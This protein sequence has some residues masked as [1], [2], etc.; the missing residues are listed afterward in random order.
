MK[1]LRTHSESAFTIVE[2][3]IVI[4]VIGILA[5]I[6]IVAYNGIQSKA[7]VA[8]LQSDLENSNKQLVAYLTT[9]STGYPVAIDCSASPAANTLCLKSSGATTYQYSVN[10]STLSAPAYCITATNGAKSYFYSPTTGTPTIGACP[11]HGVGGTAPI[12]NLSLNPSLE[13][14]Q[15][16]WLAGSNSVTINRISDSMIGSYSLAET[17]VT[18]GVAYIYNALP[19]QQPITAGTTYAVS[20]SVKV[21]TGTTK[22]FYLGMIWR[23]SAG[24][25]ISPVYSSA[26]TPSGVGVVTRLFMTATAP[27]SATSLQIQGRTD[28]AVVGDQYNW[29]G[30][31]MTTG[32]T[33]YAYADGNTSNWVWNGTTNT[34][35]STGPA[36]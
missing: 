22:P 12:T 36:S 20:M 7:T 28:A 11:G 29:D 21:V 14:A 31:M 10:N 19:S 35:T 30:L 27:A 6:T 26:V 18:A 16:Y 33:Q 8:S 25:G 13:S 17:V 4:V 9:S 5:A 3:L 15:T 34:S 23:D 24:N 32:S 1:K 2:L